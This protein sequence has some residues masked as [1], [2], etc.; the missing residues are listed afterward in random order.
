MTN[1]IN[2]LKLELYNKSCTLHECIVNKIVT[3]SIKESFVL[4]SIKNDPFIKKLKLD[5]TKIV[6]K[7]CRNNIHTKELLVKRITRNSKDVTIYKQY[8]VSNP[9][10][11]SMYMINELQF[12]SNIDIKFYYGHFIIDIKDK[13]TLLSKCDDIINGFKYKVHT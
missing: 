11:I 13:D 3:D 6:I 5:D 8:E 12:K 9:H 7:T 4:Y 10:N 2:S 1:T